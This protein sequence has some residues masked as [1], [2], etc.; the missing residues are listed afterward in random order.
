VGQGINNKEMNYGYANHSYGVRRAFDK[1]GSL[2][3]K[4]H[5]TNKE[6]K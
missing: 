2:K 1:I 3:S 6:F 5:A 4:M